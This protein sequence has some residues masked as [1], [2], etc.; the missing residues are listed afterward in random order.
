MDELKKEQHG[1]DVLYPRNEVVGG[2][3]GSFAAISDKPSPLPQL[4][5]TTILSIGA[6]A[7]MWE[8]VDLS[9]KHPDTANVLVLGVLVPAFSTVWQ[10]WQ[11]RKKRTG[12][13]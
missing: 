10:W 13:S 2:V 9:F 4:I 7:S 5:S 3:P 6:A 1:I 12:E 11:A 8:F